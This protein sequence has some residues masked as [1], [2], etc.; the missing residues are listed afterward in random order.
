[1]LN[2]RSSFSPGP[3][4]RHCACERPAR[5]SVSP[6]LRF[7]LSGDPAIAHAC[8]GSESRRKDFSGETVAGRARV[9]RRGGALTTNRRGG[10]LTT[11]IFPVP[12][13]GLVTGTEFEPREFFD[14]A[15]PVALAG[16]FVAEAAVEESLYA[17][18]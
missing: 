12:I 8:G 10:A 6:A 9:N 17:D 1:M 2:R 5:G 18:H 3:R 13:L 16:S 7:R 15:L 14:D 11:P 4:A